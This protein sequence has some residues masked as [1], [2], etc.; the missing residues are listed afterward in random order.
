MR[1]S[2]IAVA[3][4]G[5]AAAAQTPATTTKR[6]AV[7]EGIAVDSLHQDALRG[8]LLT[9]EGTSAAA[10]TDSLGKFRIDSIPPGTHRVEVTH[11]ILDSIG[12]ALFTPP[13]E[14]DAGQQLHLV[15]AIPSVQ[16]V[17]NARCTPGEQ[18]VGPGALL[19]TVQYAESGDPAD[20]AQII[21]EFVAIRIS[22]NSI[23]AV[24]YRRV[25]TVAANGH[26]K[27]CG[28]PDDL[29]GSVMAISGTDS[30]GRVGVH[31]SSQV[32]VV[33]LE[34][35]DPLPHVSSS[36]PGAPTTTVGRKGSAVLTGTVLDPSGM[37]LSRARVSVAGDT[38]AT[39]S[40]ADGRFTLTNLRSGTHTVAA[41]RL[42]FQPAE[43]A[44]TLHSRAPTHVTVK[45]GEFVAML[46]TV[47]INAKSEQALDRV[48]FNRRKQMG[49]GYYMA[50]EQISKRVAEDL[51]SLLSMAPMLRR[52]SDGG[53]TVIVGRPRGADFECV[54]YVVDGD[55]WIGGGIEDFIRSD[56]IAAIEVYSSSFVPAQF[57]RPTSDCETVVIWTK[58]K[59]R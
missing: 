35:P 58:W 33:G 55:P 16:T 5:S 41:R 22:G 24:P 21:L 37:P 45:L 39:L 30:T 7:I 2:I 42:G 53:K 46:D 25:A 18:R 54:S 48:G 20:G 13:L 17:L 47:R 43:A 49:T 52:A 23:R 56:D 44:V 57:R 32:G 34:L 19:G 14:L 12:I 29:S 40:D 59:Q 1:A 27:L 8:A 6:F 15:V 11:A 31:L 38:A 50:P 36:A 4:A 51:V 3:L 10:M 28:L 26:F 9:V